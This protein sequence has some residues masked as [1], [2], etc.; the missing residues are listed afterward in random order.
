VPFINIITP[1]FPIDAT[2]AE[3]QRLSDEF[4][5]AFQMWD[6]HRDLTIVAGTPFDV[7]SVEISPTAQVVVFGVSQVHPSGV[8]A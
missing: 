8:S 2:P 6:G 5:Q 7:R 4:L 3:R 1:T